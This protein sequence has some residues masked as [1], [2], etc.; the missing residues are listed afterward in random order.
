MS[1]ASYYKYLAKYPWYECWKGARRRCNDVNHKSYKTHGAKGIKFL[2]T[3]EECAF[4]WGRDKGCLLLIPSLDRKNGAGNY[5]ISN[6]RFIELSENC[7]L[8][9]EKR[10]G[11]LDSSNKSY[12]IIDSNEATKNW[13]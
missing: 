7:R 2:L 13:G 4:I 3:K 9:N 5:E 6:C 10:W 11:K 12:G 1:S 8:A